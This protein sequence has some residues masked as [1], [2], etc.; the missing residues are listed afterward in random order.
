MEDSVNPRPTQPRVVEVVVV[1]AETLIPVV[2]VVLSVEP[3]LQAAATSRAAPPKV[4]CQVCKKPNHAAP[5]C[6]YRFEVDYQP[7]T[8]ASASTGYGVDTNWYV[9]SGATNHVT[10]DL[11][12]LSAHDRYN[13]HVQVHTANGAGMSISYIGNTVLHT[14]SANLHLKKILHVPS[15]NKSLLSFHRLTSDN[16]AFLEFHRNFFLIKDR[17]TKKSLHQGRWFYR[18]IQIK[19]RSKRFETTL[20]H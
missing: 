14:S 13:G 8:A 1:A 4:L 7:K 6:W 20:W 9:D 18:Q 2:A 5:D 15:A 16:D 10:S 12:K 19:T 17:T 3:I 11:E